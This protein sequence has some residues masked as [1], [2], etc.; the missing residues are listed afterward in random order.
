M[1][2]DNFYP[3]VYSDDYYTV[4]AENRDDAV[5][6]FV[7]QELTDEE[8]LEY[9][10]EIDPD[11]KKMWFPLDELPE[12]YHNEEKYP[13]KDWR[14]EYTGVEITLTEAMKYSKEEIPYVICVSS[15]LA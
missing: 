4:V 9:I 8:G 3:Q 12:E 6:L 14:G 13:G 5:K 10:R 7:Y 1:T 2:R 11:K 15:E